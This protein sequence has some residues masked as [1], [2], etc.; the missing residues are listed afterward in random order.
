MRWYFGENGWPVSTINS[1]PPETNEEKEQI[2]DE[3]QEW[4]SEKYRDLIGSGDV[5][6]RPGVLRFMEEAKSKG[7]KVAFGVV[8]VGIL[9]AVYFRK[10]SI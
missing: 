7:L 1:A 10:V 3:L 6:P 2:I 8:V 9:T 5:P 4:K